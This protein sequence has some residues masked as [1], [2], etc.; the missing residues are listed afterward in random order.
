MVRFTAGL[1]PFQDRPG[2]LDTWNFGSAHSAGLHMAMCDGSVQTIAYGI[3]AI[4]HRL[5]SNRTDGE[6]LPTEPFN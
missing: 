1:I 6:A 4:T 2:V 3:T 5:L